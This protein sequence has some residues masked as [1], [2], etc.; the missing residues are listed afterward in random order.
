MTL[1]KYLSLRN[2]NVFSKILSVSLV[3]LATCICAVYFFLIPV[4]EKQLLRERMDAAKRLVE[5]ATSVMA[6][7]D[8]LAEQG[9]QSKEKAQHASL[10]ELRNLRYG[11]NDYFW[12]HD[13]EP[14]MIMHPTHP[15]LENHPLANHLDASG[16]RVF[17]KMNEL[18]GA[19]GEG[20]VAYQW[21]R[22]N[23]TVPIPKMSRIQLFKP[24][25]WVIGTGIYIEDVHTKATTIRHQVIEIGLILAGLIILYSLYAARRINRPLQQALQIACNLADDRPDMAKLEAVGNDETRRL[26]QVMKDLIVDI[27]EARNSAE[28]ANR[29]KSEFL[30]NMSHEIRTPMNGVIGMTGLLLD[31]DLN[32]EQRE[33]AEIVRKSGEN[34]LVLIDDILDFSKNEAGK[35]ELE[36]IDFDLRATLEDTADLLA[37]RASE[38]GIELVCQIDPTVPSLLKG[39]PGRVRQIILNLAG[40]G[41]KFTH[42]GDVLINASLDSEDSRSAVIRFRVSDTGIGI[43]ESRLEAIFS[44][45]TQVD[46]TTTRKY[47]GT[48]LGLSICKQ[49]AE[50][51]GGEIG[52][53]SVEGKGSSFWFTS[54][55]EK[56]A[57]AADRFLNAAADIAGTRILVVDDNATNLK[58]MDVLLKHWGCHCVTIGD[59]NAAL[60]LMSDAVEQ[61][62][63]FHI[64]LL[65]QQM[66]LMDG[67]ELGRRI[68]SDPLLQNTILIMV[69]SLGQ[70]GEAA[71]LNEIGFAGY[72]SKPVRQLHLRDS[73]RSALG[74]AFAEGSCQTL[75]VTK[76]PRAETTLL[77]SLILLVEDNLVNQKV[78][79]SLLNKLGY[80]SD[81]VKNG[82]EAIKALELRHYDLV[83]MDCLMPELDG[84]EATGM[85]R[86][87]NSKVKD[88]AVPII[89]MT[90][91]AMT[92]DREKCLFAG[93][94][95]Y[96]AKPVNKDELRQVLEKWIK[97]GNLPLNQVIPG[98]TEVFARAIL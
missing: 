70:R 72:L 44:P 39:D 10:Q 40:N 82:L 96:L 29:A 87:G 37:V 62:S 85:I 36:S 19:Q 23:S 47:G 77:C 55:F 7:Q 56:Q 48:G 21:P 45:F 11:E 92:G 64:A 86:D 52:V 78:A 31:T 66:P 84:Y 67:V 94:N 22:P 20:F 35:L 27:K 69:T 51:M 58:L 33:Y 93:M 30:A 5:V 57:E 16:Q 71:M 76:D 49:L 42:S 41:I 89:A 61:G 13:L 3:I 59:G 38:A 98:E 8:K 74:R 28:S 14:K 46:G 4:Y 12:V 1:K 90:A 50:M 15:E 24:W 83:L 60:T 25:G 95:D 2:W 81:A 32:D 17:V 65:D 26:L 6:R 73:L 91:S 54:R 43:P 18:V 79:Q 9:E 80:A 97:K 68:K 53:E 34:L 63:P 88:H 75:V